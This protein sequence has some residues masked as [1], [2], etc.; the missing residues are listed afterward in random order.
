MGHGTRAA[1]IALK[2]VPLADATSSA[3]LI[4]TRTGELAAAKS[5]APDEAM[6]AA[7]APKASDS[8]LTPLTLPGD[9]LRDQSATETA[10][11]CSHKAS[12]CMRPTDRKPFRT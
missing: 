9:S 6:D 7:V 10:T 3:A 2:A 4:T 12:P 8:E 5:P 11:P 1:N